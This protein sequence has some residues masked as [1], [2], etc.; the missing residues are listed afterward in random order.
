[1]IMK[2]LVDLDDF[3]NIHEILFQEETPVSKQY[4]SNMLLS[5]E[6]FARKHEI[7]YYLLRNSALLVFEDGDD[8][9]NLS[10]LEQELFRTLAVKACFLAENDYLVSKRPFWVT[11][12]YNDINLH[13]KDVQLKKNLKDTIVN[14]KVSESIGITINSEGEISFSVLTKSFYKNYLIGLFSIIQNWSLNSSK[15]NDELI[16]EYFFPFFLHYWNMKDVRLTSLPRVRVNDNGIFD[17]AKRVAH[18]Q[19]MFN[20]LHEIAHFGFNHIGNETMAQNVFLD[21]FKEL[22]EKQENYKEYE[23]DATAML[24]LQNFPDSEVDDIYLAI[25]CMYSFY[26]TLFVF[27]DYCILEKDISENIFQKRYTILSSVP[28]KRRASNDTRT[29]MTI[30]SSVFDKFVK[31]LLSLD[32]KEID[33]IIAYYTEN[34]KAQKCFDR[35]FGN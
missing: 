21:G 5:S 19:S 25:H 8:E 4:V 23:A 32:K 26:S 17:R 18:Y 3:N 9:Q 15:K 31:V 28:C 27:R 34:N 11:N 10:D 2:Y 16:F 24:L 33:D 6:L 7:Y 20:F 29:L 35:I 1:M 12:I 22:F 14:I 30:I 13:C